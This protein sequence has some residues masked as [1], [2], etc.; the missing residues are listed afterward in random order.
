MYWFIE[1]ALTTSVAQA[2]TAMVYPCVARCLL[3]PAGVTGG[4]E[5]RRVVSGTPEVVHLVLRGR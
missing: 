3:Y 2:S 1:E 4:S 5:A